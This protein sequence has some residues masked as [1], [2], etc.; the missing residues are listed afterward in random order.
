M[1]DT[2][3]PRSAVVVAHGFKGFKDWAFFPYLA[4]RLAA[5]GHA[6]ITFNFSGSGV[7]GG[8]DDHMDLEAFARNTLSAELEE[9]GLIVDLARQGDLLPRPPRA[10]G[11]LGH[12]RG[13]GTAI[14]HAGGRGGV[15]ALVTWSA[16]A[17]FDR[18]SEETK[19]EW[20]ERG[21]PH[22]KKINFF[23]IHK[24]RASGQVQDHV[25]VECLL[26]IRVRGGKGAH[27]WVAG[28]L[29]AGIGLEERGPE[30]GGLEFAEQREAAHVRAGSVAG[31]AEHDVDVDLDAVS[32]EPARGVDNL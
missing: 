30:V 31:Q 26:E 9:L 22:E 7:V 20:R 32:A 16:V 4:E 6:A 3:P 8:S 23:E 1:P 21:K 15:D 17:S 28:K 19:Q 14:L 5:A 12:S 25:V 2:P 29:E 13:G 18:W 27:R 11:V 10:V 24:V